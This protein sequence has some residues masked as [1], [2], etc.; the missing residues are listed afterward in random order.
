MVGTDIVQSEHIGKKVF[1]YNEVSLLVQMVRHLAPMTFRVFDKE[2]YHYVFVRTKT[3][4][5]CRSLK[6]L[7]LEGFLSINNLL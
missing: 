2:H 6:V 1:P 7:A 5:S 4:F 3:S